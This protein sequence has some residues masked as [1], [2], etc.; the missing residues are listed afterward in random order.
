MVP[1]GARFA[2]LLRLSLSSIPIPYKYIFLRILCLFIRLCFFSFGHPYNQYPW[3]DFASASSTLLKIFSLDFL[4]Y[5]N[6]S[7]A[8]NYLLSKSGSSSWSNMT[9]ILGILNTTSLIQNFESE[10]VLIV[11]LYNISPNTTRNWSYIEPFTGF[12]TNPTFVEWIFWS[13]H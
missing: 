5:I 10:S 13:P 1:V 9:W 8:V 2:G 7:S 3:S 11:T 12:R 4:K 6:Y